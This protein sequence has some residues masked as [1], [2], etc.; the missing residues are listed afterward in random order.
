MGIIGKIECF[1]DWMVVLNIHNF[2]ASSDYVLVFV[3]YY[4]LYS[5]VPVEVL[6]WKQ[7]MGT[8]ICLASVLM[9]R[10]RQLSTIRRRIRGIY[11]VNFE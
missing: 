2:H 7:E 6:R 4:I 3:T 10:L 1:N 5:A 9:C 11:K 8:I